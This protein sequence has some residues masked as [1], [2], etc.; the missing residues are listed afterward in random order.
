MLAVSA[1][2]AG[3]VKAQEEDDFFADIDTSAPDA[4]SAEE[5]AADEAEGGTAA[6][7]SDDPIIAAANALANKPKEKHFYILPFCRKLD[8]HAQVLTPGTNDW[9]DIKEGKFYPLGTTYRTVGAD[10][11]LCIKFGKDIEVLVKGEASFGTR[12][13]A[14]SE[15]SRTVMLDSGTIDVKIP[16]SFPS[17]NELFVV[18]APGFKAT[19]LAGESLYR[20]TKTA[21]GDKATV[22]CVTGTMSLS[23]RHFDI[24]SMRTANELK[25]LS[26]EDYLFTGL[27]GSRGDIPVVLDQGQILVMDYGTGESHIED[28]TLE[29]RLSPQTAVRIHRAVPTIGDRMSVTIMTFDAAGDLKNRCAFAERTYQVNSGELGPTS[30]KERAEIAKRA[31]EAAEAAGVS[32]ESAETEEVEAGEEATAGD[33]GSDDDFEF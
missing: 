18:T 3:S 6:S 1:L 9:A 12:A 25:I 5:P 30:S 19:N 11:E 32:A 28:K 24:P 8:G 22:R 15:K 13:Q 27:Y 26:A 7:E 23:G 21:D 33:S 20:Y 10:T 17:S 2:V 29:W 14:L 31:A 4:E 16:R